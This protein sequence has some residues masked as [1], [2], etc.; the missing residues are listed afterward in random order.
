MLCF[1][2]E[3]RKVTTSG[4]VV[5]GRTRGGDA[6]PQFLPGFRIS[7]NQRLWSPGLLYTEGSPSGEHHREAIY[8]P[9]GSYEGCRHPRTLFLSLLRRTKLLRKVIMGQLNGKYLHWAVAGTYLFSIT[10]R[11]IDGR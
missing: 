9:P 11:D 5:R 7:A 10:L 3:Y 8:M 4:S 1:V 2:V 6:T